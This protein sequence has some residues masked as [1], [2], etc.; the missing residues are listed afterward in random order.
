MKHSEVLQEIKDWGALNGWECISFG[1]SPFGDNGIADKMLI[2][3]GRQIWVEGKRDKKD[4]LKISQ[5]Q[6]REKIVSNGGEYMVAHRYEDLEI[7]KTCT[8]LREVQDDDTLFTSD[9]DM[10]S[11]SIATLGSRGRKN[12][13]AKGSRKRD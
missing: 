8:H 9:S 13:T 7:L 6:F 11:M 1:A 4:K 5:I 2:K 10:V 3:E 12:R